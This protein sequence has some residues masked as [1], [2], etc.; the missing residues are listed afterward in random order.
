MSA[1]DAVPASPDGVVGLLLAAGRSTRFG[2]NKLCHLLPDGSP[3]GVR[4]ALNL[5]AGAGAVLAV[6]RPDD[7]ALQAALAAAGIDWLPCA[8]AGAGMAAS[9]ACGVG[10]TAGARGWLIALADMPY[11]RPATI[12][13]V[14]QAIVAGAP[15]AA[16][17]HAGR[18]GHPV[19]FG[20]AF[21]AQL[22]AL[23]GDEGA[24]QLIQRHAAALRRIDGDD[25]GVLA[26]ID[27]PADVQPADEDGGRIG[28]VPQDER[29]E[30]GTPL[31]KSGR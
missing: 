12:A 19:G 2:S 21:G 20:A 24:R 8:D 1:V 13:A 26:D 18:R 29:T 25:A 7:H 10:A 3:V 31:P 16:P 27:V 23:R 6:V 4:S 11:V 28:A 22:C 5:R 17:F 14:A 15:L 9:I 30:A